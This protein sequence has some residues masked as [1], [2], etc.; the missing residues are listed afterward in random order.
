[1][2]ERGEKRKCVERE[3]GRNAMGGSREKKITSFDWGRRETRG[4]R[5]RREGDTGGK[6]AK[7]MWH[8]DKVNS[9]LEGEFNRMAGGQGIVELT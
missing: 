4:V 1:M 5:A 9:K 3:P 7:K 2:G 6:K 8:C